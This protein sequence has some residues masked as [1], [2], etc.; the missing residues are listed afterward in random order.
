MWRTPLRHEY[1]IS[2]EVQ[3]TAYWR[4]D[5]GAGDGLPRRRG[6]VGFVAGR[7]RHV[8]DAALLEGVTTA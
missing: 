7:A 1:T 4:A 2:D 5:R 8:A 6:T 3:E